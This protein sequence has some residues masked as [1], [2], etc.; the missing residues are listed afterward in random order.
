MKTE[1][2]IGADGKHRIAIDG[3]RVWLF[4]EDDQWIA[5]GID[6]DYAASGE[7]V[8]RA[9]EMFEL[10]FCLTLVENIRRYGSIERFV[11]KRVPK[12][13]EDGWQRAL[14]Q[15]RLLEEQTPFSVPRDGSCQGV[16]RLLPVS[17]RPAAGKRVTHYPRPHRPSFWMPI[18]AP[19]WSVNALK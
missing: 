1:H 9:K 2:S 8:E 19:S 7:T 17:A 10:G 18:D 5:Q 14:D 11:S 6:I 16:A 3:L 12:E 4:Q 13:I 15:H